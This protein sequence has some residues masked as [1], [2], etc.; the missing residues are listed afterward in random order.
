MKAQYEQ[1]SLYGSVIYGGYKGLFELR[2]AHLLNK[3]IVEEENMLKDIWAMKG[4]FSPAELKC[5][6]Y[7]LPILK[8]RAI[9]WGLLPIAVVALEYLAI[10]GKNISLP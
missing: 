5:A 10:R 3:Y 8:R 7:F 4:N 9:Q 1:F 6:K 2:R